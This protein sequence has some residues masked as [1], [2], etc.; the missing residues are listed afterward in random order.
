MVG[1]CMWTYKL[2]Y[3]RLRCRILPH[4]CRISGSRVKASYE[5]QTQKRICEEL[6]LTKEP[7]RFRPDNWIP[8]CSPRIDQD[9]EL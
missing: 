6:G 2:K 1:L 5:L 9:R 3:F 7:V 8:P 4:L